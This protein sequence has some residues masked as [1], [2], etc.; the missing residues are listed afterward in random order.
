MLSTTGASGWLLDEDE[1][2]EPDDPPPSSPP[3]SGRLDEDELELPDELPEG[4]SW[5]QGQPV[6][7]AASATDKSRMASFFARMYISSLLAHPEKC[8]FPDGCFRGF[9]VLYYNKN[10][11]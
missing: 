11:T 10:F 4:S 9:P 7:M 2:D 1:L 5:S 3:S 6:S 8:T